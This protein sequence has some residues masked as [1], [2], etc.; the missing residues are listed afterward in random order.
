MPRA[1]QT[2]AP[3]PPPSRAQPCLGQPSLGQAS[4]GKES[5]GWWLWIGG[6]ILI[7]T[8][9]RA[10]LAFTE[11]S[12]FWP[13]EVY[14]SLEQAHRLSFGVGLIPWEFRDGARNWIFPTLIAGVWRAASWAGVESSLAL[15]GLAR[16]AVVLGTGVTLWLSARLSARLASPRAALMTVLVLSVLPASLVFSYR[17]LSESVSAPLVALSALQLLDRSP[18]RA[19]AAGTCIAFAT[20]LRYQNGLFG[21]GFLVWLFSERR[22]RE[23]LAFCGAGAA[24]FFAGGLLD[25]V[26]WGQPFH[27]LITYVNFNLVRGGSSTFGVEPAWFYAQSLWSSTGATSVILAALAIVGSRRVPALAWTVLGYIAVHS[28]IPHK[29]LRFLMPVLPL[30]SVLVGLGGEDVLAAAG[31]QS[32]WCW[33]GLGASALT[34]LLHLP[35]LTYSRMGQYLGTAR[36]ARTVWHADAEANRMLAAAGERED[37]C[38]LAVLGLR[39]AFTGAYTYFHN[40]A[41][42]FYRHGLCGEQHAAN[43]LLAP[44][45][46]AEQLVPADYEQ[47]DSLGWLGLYRR[48]GECT[49]QRGQFDSYLDGARDMGLA[50]QVAAQ[51]SDGAV[52]FDLLNDAGS[53]AQGWGHGEVID[54]KPAR[55]ATSRR[56]VVTFYATEEGAAYSLSATLRAFEGGSDQRLRLSLNSRPVHEGIVPVEM[57]TL[58]ANLPALRVGPNELIFELSNV[59]QPSEEDSRQLGA[60]LQSLELTPLAD[61]FDFQASVPVEAEHLVAGFGPP[62]TVEGQTFRWN[63]GAF[64]IVQGNLVTPDR[65]HILSVDA[66]SMTGAAGRPRVAI[67]GRPLGELAFSSEWTRQDLLVPPE[68]LQSGVNQVRFDYDASVIPATM[69]PSSTDRRE[70]AV[71]FRSV[72]LEPLTERTVIDVG[73]PQ[74]RRSLLDGWSHDERDRKRTVVWTD[75]P[76]AR[77]KV[78]VTGE[79]SA[80]ETEAHLRIEGHAYAPAV[81]VKV[82]LRLN[83]SNIGSFSPDAAWRVHELALPADH[84]RQGPNILEL[85]FDRTARPK[86][87]EAQSNDTRALALRVDSIALTR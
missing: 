48:P 58:L 9:V 29:E 38:G 54:C 10:W 63:D 6:L 4:A 1:S 37:L 82:E 70:L 69:D 49:L 39:P 73:T 76:V 41:P 26:T 18:R 52:R 62:E 15:V 20:L 77:V 16:L 72:T 53:F 46:R 12:I 23:A 2:A 22:T 56:A 21:L 8:V 3:A 57:T 50:R 33:L 43:Y 71:R 75:G 13:D 31:R 14:Q 83:G 68:V 17:T 27:S 35:E 47:V 45:Y 60:L 79:T 64:S 19:I 40:E 30:V 65:P 11:H 67:N 44:F 61:N 51:A 28:L 32:A 55:W 34:P 24:A 87:H 25:W 80:S 7:A 81:P 42:L 85:R 78:W 36:G 84:L 59:W 5:S 74:G 86:D 66:A